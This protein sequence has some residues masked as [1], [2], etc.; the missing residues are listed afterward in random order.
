MG[1]ACPFVYYIY[2]HPWPNNISINKKLSQIKK[3][4]FMGLAVIMFVLG[5]VVGWV[6]G[7]IAKA[8]NR[9]DKE[10]K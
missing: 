2:V 1:I 7:A 8:L 4:V 3:G 9:T 6:C 10:I 5:F